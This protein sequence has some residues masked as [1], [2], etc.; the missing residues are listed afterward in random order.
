[1]AWSAIRSSRNLVTV[2]G[3]MEPSRATFTGIRMV[4][5]RLDLEGENALLFHG[6]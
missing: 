2:F 3:S 1:L 6:D 5:D 4:S